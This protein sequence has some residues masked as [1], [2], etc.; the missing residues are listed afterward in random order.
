VL[1][2][3]LSEATT[4]PLCPNLPILPRYLNHLAKHYI[5]L[6]RFEFIDKR[7]YSGT[8]FLTSLLCNYLWLS[9]V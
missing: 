2:D 4:M 5:T 6:H 1:K 8:C 7:A 3:R 9:L